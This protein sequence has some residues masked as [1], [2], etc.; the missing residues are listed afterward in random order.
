MRMS[1]L[2]AG[3]DAGGGVDSTYAQGTRIRDGNGRR[4]ARARA[5]GAGGPPLREHRRGLPGHV[6]EQPGAEFVELQMYQRGTE[7][8]LH[9]ARAWSSTTL[10]A[11]SPETLAS[12]GRH[13]RRQ[14]AHAALSARPRWRRMSGQQAD[15]EYG[16]AALANAGGGVCLLSRR[17]RH[18]S[19]ASRGA[20]PRS[21][22]PG[23]P[24]L[25]SLT[26]RR[27]CATSA[28]AATRC[29]RAATTRTRAST[30]SRP[31]AS[32]RHSRTPRLD[33]TRRCPNTQITK[34]PKAK[35][36]DRTPK[37]EFSGGD[38]FLCSL[39]GSK[40]EAV[41]LGRLR[42]GQAVEGQA[43]V[44]RPGDRDRRLPSTARPATYSWKIVKKR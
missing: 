25:R 18:P 30:T 26:A 27:S 17:L 19:T 34:K 31:A 37:F 24:R 40:A 4:A 6:S 35:T 20:P 42:A 12:A 13:E 7:Q 10:R 9:P 32:P 1:L 33:S 43:Q 28:L 23:R 16:S 8:L 44:R 11:P 14:P 29:S 21:P 38:G 22:A 2:T 36:K 15:V 39:D 3:R 5:G 41:R